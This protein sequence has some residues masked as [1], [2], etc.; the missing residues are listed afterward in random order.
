MSLNAAEGI[1]TPKLSKDVTDK[2]LRK[3]VEAFDKSLPAFIKAVG[4][5]YA[6]YAAQFKAHLRVNEALEAAQADRALDPKAKKALD[7]FAKEFKGVSKTLWNI[8]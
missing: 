8:A 1:K 7:D 4:A 6:V 5:F 3:A 2:D